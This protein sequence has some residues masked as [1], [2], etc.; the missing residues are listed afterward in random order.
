MI[1]IILCDDSELEKVA[2]IAKKKNFGLEFQSFH[3][4]KNYLNKNIAIHKK[5][6]EGIKPIFM[7]GIFPD[8]NPGTTDPDLR[9]IAKKRFNQTYKV[10][11]ELNATG[12]VY[13]VGYVPGTGYPPNWAKRSIAFWEEFLKG[14]SKK[15]N[16]YIENMLEH[17]P[18]MLYDIIGGLNRDNVKVCLDLGHAHCYSKTSVLKWIE[19]LQDKIGY[20]HIHDNNGLKD[21]HI[22]IGK[23]NIPMKRVLNAL[24]K[25]APNAKWALEVNPKDMNQTLKWLEENKYIN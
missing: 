20:V 17:T 19:K 3:S 7:H 24:K 2:T 11:R 14:K 13:H 22:G 6:L 15:V 10:A 4:Q 5:Q 1:Q 25:Y 18:D 16:F 8:L 23:G 12:I 21:E 9:K